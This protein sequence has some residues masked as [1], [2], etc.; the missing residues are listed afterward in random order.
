MYSIMDLTDADCGRK[1]NLFTF[2]FKAIR[3][4]SKGLSSP[5]LFIISART[6][7]QASLGFFPL[8]EKPRITLCVNK[9]D[10][11]WSFLQKTQVCFLPIYECSRPKIVFVRQNL[12]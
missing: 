8:K 4:I 10:K 1:Y 5:V 6:E 9:C 2:R 11:M 12:Y 7:Q 3:P